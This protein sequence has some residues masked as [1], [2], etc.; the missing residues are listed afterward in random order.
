[1]RE[2]KL[3]ELAE[4]ICEL[5][6]ADMMRLAKELARMIE[7]NVRTAPKTVADFASILIDWAEAQE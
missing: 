5:T 3:P 7:P 6:Y 2:S 4:F 1:M